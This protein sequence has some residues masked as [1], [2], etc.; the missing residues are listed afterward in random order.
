MKKYIANFKVYNGEAT[1][2]ISVKTEANNQ[3]EAKK[4]F[5]EYECEG[6]LDIWKLLYIEEVKTFNDLWDLI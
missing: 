5:K 1:Y 3:S 6:D 4:Y 2:S